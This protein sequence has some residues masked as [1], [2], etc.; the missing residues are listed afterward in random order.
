MPELPEVEFARKQLSRWLT[1]TKIVRATVV[2][3][4]ILDAKVKSESVAKALRGRSV[5]HVERRGKWLR[6]VLDDGFIFS[7]FG[8]TVQAD[9]GIV[10]S[11]Q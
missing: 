2:D 8:M 7:H 6:I 3:A 11:G 1:K 10:V 9:G 4:R 5:K